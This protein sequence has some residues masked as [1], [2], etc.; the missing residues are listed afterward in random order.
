M[1]NS[2]QPKRSTDV[3][4]FTDQQ[5]QLG[6]SMPIYAVYWWKH[7]FTLSVCVHLVFPG[8]PYGFIFSLIPIQ[9][10]S[11]FFWGCFRKIPALP[12]VIPHVLDLDSKWAFLGLLEPLSVKTVFTLAYFQKSFPGGSSGEDPACQCRRHR[13]VGSTLGEGRAPGRGHGNPLQYF[14]WR[15]PG[16]E[17]C[18]PWQVI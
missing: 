5:G 10:K 12:T 9:R 8:F 11:H 3:A 6:V 4:F 7:V 16:T 2:N 1:Y 18:R 14:A 17:S 13:A 15:I